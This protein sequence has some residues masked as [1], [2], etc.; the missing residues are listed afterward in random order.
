[1]LDP[2]LVFSAVIGAALALLGQAF[3]HEVK[4]AR[5]ARRLCVALWEELSA[6]Y[7]YTGEIPNFAGFSSQ[8]FDSL[9]RDLADA[10]PESLARDV[11]RYHWRM[12]YLEEVKSVT[13]GRVNTHFLGEAQSLR[14]RLLKRLDHYSKRSTGDVLFEP[15][16]NCDVSL[17]VGNAA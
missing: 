4:R 5:T 15:Q 9:F 16:E 17:E 10:L 1:M 3:S 7:F 12:K 8:V 14:E 11:M 6:V 13:A 2:K